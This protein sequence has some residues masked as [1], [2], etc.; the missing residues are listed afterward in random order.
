MEIPRAE[1][2]EDKVTGS[3]MLDQTI[4]WASRCWSIYWAI[5]LL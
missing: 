1:R 2:T 4:S 5:I 3:E